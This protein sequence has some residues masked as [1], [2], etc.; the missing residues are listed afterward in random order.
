MTKPSKLFTS[1]R[2]NPSQVIAFRDFVSLLTSFGFEQKR[3][4]GSHRSYR[5]PAVAEVIT[6]QPRGADARPYQ[7]REFL[8][9]VE[10]YNLRLEE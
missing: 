4:R 10:A 3:Q 6:I 8:S 7:V 2:H 1:L 5:H 9:I